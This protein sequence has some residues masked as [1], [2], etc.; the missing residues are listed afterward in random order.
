LAELEF[1]KQSKPEW[2]EKRLRGDTFAA[3]V[4]RDPKEGSP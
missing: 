3:K 2:A 4:E 1:Q